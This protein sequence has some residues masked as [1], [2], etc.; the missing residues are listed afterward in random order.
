MVEAQN[1]S[2]YVNTDKGVVNSPSA[3]AFAPR[4]VAGPDSYIHCV[5]HKAMANGYNIYYRKIPSARGILGSGSGLKITSSNTVSVPVSLKNIVKDDVLTILEGDF[6]GSY[7][8]LSTSEAST[9]WNAVIEPSVTYTSS[10]F[11]IL[12]NNIQATFE[13]T[14]AAA[15]DDA[16]VHNAEDAAKTYP[17]VVLENG[18]SYIVAISNTTV[19]S[20][21]QRGSQLK[22]Y[23]SSGTTS[24]NYSVG[25]VLDN[26]NK[27]RICNG[28]TRKTYEY[29]VTIIDASNIP[30]GLYKYEIYK[31]TVEEKII[32]SGSDL[33]VLDRNIVKI[34]SSSIDKVKTGY[35]LQILSGKYEGSYVIESFDIT[36][37]TLNWNQNIFPAIDEVRFI[38]NG[39]EGSVSVSTL[40]SDLLISKIADPNAALSY[41]ITLLTSSGLACKRDNPVVT[42]TDVPTIASTGLRAGDGLR[43]LTG[44]NAGIYIIQSII[45]Q[46]SIRIA[47]TPKSDSQNDSFFVTREVTG[48]DIQLTSS[49]STFYRYSTTSE[50]SGLTELAY[51]KT[52]EEYVKNYMQWKGF[53]GWQETSWYYDYIDTGN[54]SA[55]P[56]PLLSVADE[57]CRCPFTEVDL[58]GASSQYFT[59]PP[60]ASA[61]GHAFF[62]DIAVDINGYLHVVWM[63]SRH[64]SYEVYYATNKD[65][66]KNVRITNSVGDSK[67][68]RIACTIY[69]D[70]YVAWQD[71]RDGIFDIFYCRYT[72]EDGWNCSGQSGT[73]TKLTR[74]ASEA[75][76]PDMKASPDGTVHL[77]FQMD[78]DGYSQIFYSR[79][80]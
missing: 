65:N 63:D 40:E 37:K 76:Y 36:A 54:Y 6:A 51:N 43:I 70:I 33:Q 53:S 28:G 41:T 31:A 34:L 80:A 61:T 22:L 44:R 26:T 14:P 60:S 17:D 66:W 71:D 15:N 49:F 62:P 72:I 3:A 10:P 1:Q 56:V 55:P 5:F 19:V 64:D 79:T 7:N 4:S 48:T 25:R 58:A 32:A 42:Y 57:P 23:S 27:R 75:K 20:S 13:S 50:F 59:K 77:V 52:R 45:D 47:P 29:L 39:K 12:N 46:K 35:T 2:E 21:V 67:Y 68:P 38:I 11:I 69:G 18:E 73:D 24:S 74:S 16:C 78:V 9:S 8:I 30:P